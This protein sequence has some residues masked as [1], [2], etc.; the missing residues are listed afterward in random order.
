MKRKEGEGG[1]K[2]TNEKRRHG[3]KGTD[4]GMEERRKGNDFD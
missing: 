3:Y 4:E 2:E 1:H